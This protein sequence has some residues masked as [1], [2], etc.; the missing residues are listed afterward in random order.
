MLVNVRTLFSCF[1]ENGNFFL[2]E[3]IRLRAVRCADL[4]VECRSPK[5]CRFSPLP[6]AELLDAKTRSAPAIRAS[7]A[8]LKATLLVDRSL[9]SY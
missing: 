5:S 2:A 3:T 1:C 7:F 6:M 4:C 8:K 9:G